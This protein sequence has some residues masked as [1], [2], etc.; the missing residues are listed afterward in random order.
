MAKKKVKSEGAALKKAK[1][2][3]RPHKGGKKKGAGKAATQ[4]AKMPRHNVPARAP[5]RHHICGSCQISDSSG[6]PFCT[7]PGLL[8]IAAAIVLIALQHPLAKY[9]AWLF[10]IAA[11]LS[12]WLMRL[13]KRHHG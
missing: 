6:C 13:M 9:V 7:W 4:I 5:A 12:P 3:A 11:I 1:K 8:L 10:L 2:A